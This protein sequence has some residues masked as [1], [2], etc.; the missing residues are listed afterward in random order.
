MRRLLC[1]SCSKHEPCDKKLLYAESWPDPAEFIRVR[2]GQAKLPTQ[3]QRTLYVDGDP[4]HLSLDGFNCDFCS[5]LIKPGDP[6]T[7]ET[8]WLGTQREPKP[9]EDE[10]LTV[11]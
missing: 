10:F 2:T 11:T 7:A 9:W 6:I 5:A 1:S 3:E 8:I 4:Q